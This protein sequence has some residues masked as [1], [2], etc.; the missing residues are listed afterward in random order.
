MSTR[1]KIL[2]LSLTALLC[3]TSLAGAEIAQKGE[4]RVKVSGSF[5]PQRLP[6]SGSAPIS[7]S[8]GG[9]ISNTKGGAAP[10]LESLRIELNKGGVI[11]SVGLPLCS[12]GAIQTASS[13]RALSA[14]KKAL[15]GEGSFGAEITLAGQEPYPITGK[16]LAFNGKQGSR[17]V[18]FGHI[19]AARPFAT[20]FVIVFSI[21]KLGKGTWG[22]AL[23]AKLPKSL[24]TWGKLT[25]IKLN[26]SRRYS[27]AGKQHSYIS[28][29]CPAPKGLTRAPFPFAKASFGFD[30]G[31]V[32]SSTLNRSCKVR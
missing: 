4:V 16:L 12:Y 6:R 25:G 14:C 18:L 19:Y 22:T 24:S 1:T 7:V 30:G 32:L 23:D 17:P 27:R 9:E 10:R 31:K 21:Q 2:A 8:V 5:T 20:S 13:Q 26:L 11:D 3:L 15:V 29:G 28:A